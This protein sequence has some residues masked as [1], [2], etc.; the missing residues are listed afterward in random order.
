MLR[1]FAAASPLPGLELCDPGQVLERQPGAVLDGLRG[2]LF[3]PHE[4]NVDPRVAIPAMHAWLRATGAQVHSGSPVVAVAPHQVQLSN[5]ARWHAERIVICSGDDFASLLPDAFA[6]SGM[7]RCRL[8]MLSLGPQPA[9]FRLGPMLAAGLTLLH[10]QGFGECSSLPRLR[11]RMAEQF[12]PLLARGIHVMVSQGDCGRLIVGDS[13]DY[14]EPFAPGLN[15]ATERL[16][17]DYLATFFTA[18]NRTVQRRWTG[19]YAKCQNGAS[20]FRS[21]PLPGVEIVT[22]VGGS[23]MTRSLALGEQTI[24]TW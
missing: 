19:T 22:G 7:A 5:G 3:S 10:Y 23:G 24:A 11:T 4:A 1:E 15:A 8:Q 14:D 2:G 17:L 21:K 20:Q 12:E 13:H 6:S 9:G 16:I 18:P